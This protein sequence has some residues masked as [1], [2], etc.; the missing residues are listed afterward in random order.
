M[1]H[2]GKGFYQE[3]QSVET[4][5]IL[6]SITIAYQEMKITTNISSAKL[7]QISSDDLFFCPCLY[8]QLVQLKSYRRQK[9]LYF[10]G[11]LGL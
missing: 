1:Q 7:N 6:F 4:L 9:R 10:A 2:L 5:I 3:N 11:H 8:P